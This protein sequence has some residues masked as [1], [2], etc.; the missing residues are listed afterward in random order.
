MAFGCTGIKHFQKTT[1]G[2]LENSD[3]R[4]EKL[5]LSGCL[6]PKNLGCPGCLKY[7]ESGNKTILCGMFASDCFNEDILFTARQYNDTIGRISIER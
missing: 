4:P 6:T 1:F 7:S 3:L 2:C 5:G